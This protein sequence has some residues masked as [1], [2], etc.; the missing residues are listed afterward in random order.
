MPCKMQPTFQSRKLYLTEMF[1]Q[2]IYEAIMPLRVNIAHASQM[3]AIGTASDKLGHRCLI[4]PGMSAIEQCLGGACGRDQ[5]LGHDQIPEAE[6]CAHRFGKSAQ[7]HYAAVI[8][9]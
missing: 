2:R 4:Q 3:V 6:P 9:K 8:I 7:I 5:C 1:A